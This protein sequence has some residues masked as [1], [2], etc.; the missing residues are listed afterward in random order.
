MNSIYHDIALK[1]GLS[2]SAFDIL[3]AI[4]QLGD[5]CLQK[6]ICEMTFL[7]KQT[8]HSSIQ[9]LQRGGWLRLEQG[10]GRNM[11]IY[12]TERGA[13]LLEEKIRKA[14]ELEERSFEDMSE[15]EVKELLRLNA[16]YTA[17]LRKNSG[18]LL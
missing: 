10:K 17:L 2:D 18:G 8:I 3:Y 1:L 14:I 9:K 4:C 13:W 7:S 15:E 5:G 12:V 11:H 16:K 6:D